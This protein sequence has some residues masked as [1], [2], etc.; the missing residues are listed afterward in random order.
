MGAATDLKRYNERVGEIR[1]ALRSA[2]DAG[3]TLCLLL[4]DVEQEGV[5][6]LGGHASFE[7]F[8]AAEFP[9]SIGTHRYRSVIDAIGVYGEDFVRMVGAESAHALCNPKILCDEKKRA[10]LVEDTLKVSKTKG[11]AP[12][13]L[14][15]RRLVRHHAGEVQRSNTANRA[16]QLRAEEREIDELRRGVRELNAKLRAAE[17]A[18]GE[19]EKRA[20]KAEKERDELKRRNVLLSKEVASLEKRR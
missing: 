18:R 11:V 5:W 1:E 16:S 3:V 15:I 13:P 10:A 6:K 9:N 8:L 20:A 7:N 19:A 12:G 2:I 14:E 4:R 17:R